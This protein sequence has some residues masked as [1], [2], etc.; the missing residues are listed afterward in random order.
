MDWF[1]HAA[2]AFEPRRNQWP[3]PGM[4]ARHLFT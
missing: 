2:R 1:E 4:F 3:T